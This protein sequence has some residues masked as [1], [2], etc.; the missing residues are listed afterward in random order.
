M[1]WH[2]LHRYNAASTKSNKVGLSTTKANFANPVGVQGLGHVSSRHAESRARNQPLP[3]DLRYGA[4]ARMVK[5]DRSNTLNGWLPL[6]HLALPAVTTAKALS[7]LLGASG[8]SCGTK[9]YPAL[10]YSPVP[11]L[12]ITMS[13][14]E[15]FK[16]IGMYQST[17]QSLTD[18]MAPFS[19]INLSR[20]V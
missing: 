1:S 8:S 14:T 15:A 16:D 18:C 13:S 6:F 9:P 2:F 10:V 3:K 11:C 4:M 17:D 7:G 5:L 19:T 20:Q 12:K